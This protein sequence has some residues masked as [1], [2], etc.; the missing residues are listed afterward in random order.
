MTSERGIL[1]SILGRSPN[2]KEL[3]GHYADMISAQEKLKKSGLRSGDN[4]LYTQA[5]DRLQRLKKEAEQAGF[6]RQ[7][8][9][10]LFR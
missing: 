5:G 8:Y 4:Q 7:D 1:K 6:T 9:P 10:G 2:E 3:A